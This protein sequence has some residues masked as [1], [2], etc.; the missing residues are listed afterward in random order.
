MRNKFIIFLGL[1]LFLSPLPAWE[2]MYGDMNTV[3]AIKDSM[4]NAGWEYRAEFPYFRKTARTASS[5]KSCTFSPDGEYIYVTLLGQPRVAAQIFS[6]D[7]LKLV[8][9]LY[10]GADD[11]SKDYGYSEGVCRDADDSFWFTRMTT[12]HYFVYHPDTD[13]LEAGR[14]TGG[15]WTK[16]LEFSPNQQQIAMSHWVSK[17]VSVFDVGSRRIIRNLNTSQIPRGLAWIGNDTLAVTLYGGENST[18]CGI[19]IFDVRSGKMV[20]NI[21]EYRSAM[22][23][24]RYDPHTKMLFYDDMRFALVYKYDWINRR[25]IAK[26]EVDS[27]PNTIQLSPGGR[28]LFVSCRG[29]NNPQGYTLRSPRNGEVMVIETDSMKILTS[30]VQGNQPTGLGISPDGRFLATTDFMDRRLNLYLIA[31]PRSRNDEDPLSGTLEG[32]IY[33]MGT[34]SFWWWR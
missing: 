21:M 7:S 9:T 33:E 10:P 4:L 18:D 6:R 16:S 15:D 22:R 24:V 17:R 1:M 27:H 31:D 12:N 13:S 14:F 25:T 8:N 5:P 32:N 20:Q 29:P 26:V 19:E 34:R 28:H 2:L 30:W 11:P 3:E 23:D